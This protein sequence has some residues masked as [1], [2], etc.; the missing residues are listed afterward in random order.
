MHSGSSSNHIADPD[1]GLGAPVIDFVSRGI[2]IVSI[3]KYRVVPS[4]ASHYFTMA[5]RDP[6]ETSFAWTLSLHRI[7]LASAVKIFAS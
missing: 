3:S 4:S 7:Q 6:A 5:S 1:T 2:D